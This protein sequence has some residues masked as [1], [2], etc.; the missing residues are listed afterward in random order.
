MKKVLYTVTRVGKENTKVSGVGCIT[1]TD[2]V[3]AQISKSSES[4][5]SRETDTQLQRGRRRRGLVTMKEGVLYSAPSNTYYTCIPINISLNELLI[6]RIIKAQVPELLNLVY[7]LL[8]TF[9]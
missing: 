3:T 1:D 4:G 5:Q 6:I 7:N 8:M 9:I 2:L